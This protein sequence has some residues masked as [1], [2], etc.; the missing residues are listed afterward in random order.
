MLSVTALTCRQTF[1]PFSRISF[2]IFIVSD[3]FVHVPFSTLF[4]HLSKEKKHSRRRRPCRYTEKLTLSPYGWLTICADLT[5][6]RDSSLLRAHASCSF[7]LFLFMFDFSWCCDWV[8]NLQRT[9]W[10]D[11]SISPQR[12]LPINKGGGNISL[13]LLCSS[14]FVW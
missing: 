7:F 1:F 12:K 8:C 2:N 14:S 4:F 6:D 9:R 11:F 10:D 3:S 13:I 5:P